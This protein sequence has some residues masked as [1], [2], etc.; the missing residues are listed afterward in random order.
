MYHHMLQPITV[1]AYDV[2]CLIFDLTVLFGLY[3]K[4]KS[5]GKDIPIWR[6]LFSK[7]HLECASF[8]QD[9]DLIAPKLV[10]ILGITTRVSSVNYLSEVNSYIIASRKTT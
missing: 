10:H 2:P 3:R 7:Y 5:A 1:P 9:I 8:K 4:H 6:Y